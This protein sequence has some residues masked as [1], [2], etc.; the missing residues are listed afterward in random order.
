[1]VAT[2][3]LLNISLCQKIFFIYG[4]NRTIAKYI[5][6]SKKIFNNMALVTLTAPDSPMAILAAFNHRE[7]ERTSACPIS[8]SLR[9]I[10]WW[11]IEITVSNL[12]VTIQYQCSACVHRNLLVFFSRPSC[13]FVVVMSMKRLFLTIFMQVCWTVTFASAV[14]YHSYLNVYIEGIMPLTKLTDWSIPI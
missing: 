3:L 9:P 8:D 12:E 6:V 7:S 14:G 5:A 11:Y 10:S 2:G 1:M 4:G 13:S